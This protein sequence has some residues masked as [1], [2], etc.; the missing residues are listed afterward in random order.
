M[1]ETLPFTDPAD[2]ELFSYIY[3]LDNLLC[4]CNTAKD[5]LRARHAAERRCILLILDLYFKYSC[6]RSVAQYVHV[7]VALMLTLI[8]GK[9]KEKAVGGGEDEP[10]SQGYALAEHCGAGEAVRQVEWGRCYVS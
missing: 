1:Q 3:P 6:T 5:E 7:D 4:A 8:A 9:E 10:G 2:R